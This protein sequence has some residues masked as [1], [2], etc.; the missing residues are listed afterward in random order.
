MHNQAV[1]GVIEALLIVAM[2]AMIIAIIQLQ[3]IPQVMT[4]K[5]AEHMDQVFNQFSSLKS[6]I[7]LQA[8]TQSSAPI[9]SMITLDSKGLPYFIT[10][11]SFGELKVEENSQYKITM[12]PPPGSLPSGTVTLTSIEYNG[13]NSYF[14]DQSYILEGGGIIV[15]QPDGL[16]VMRADPSI[17]A[18]NGSSTITIHF[19]LPYVVAFAGK[20]IASGNGE[21]SKCFIRTNYSSN[22]THIDSIPAGGY[23]R[24]YTNY[25]NA[26]NESL[27]N[28]FGIYAIH[29]YIHINEVS[30][31][32]T[33]YIEITPGS[34]TI[35]LQLNVINMYVQIGQGWV[36]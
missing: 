35:N 28:L 13:D 16:P 1:A 22:R 2:I 7:D 17:L 27:Y 25:L 26:W 3:Y 36:Q 6:M 32:P 34:K 24:I 30:A 12:N 31:Q 19:D 5:E 33:S 29:G 18:V 21:G 4:Q 10:A 8:T 20:N 14:V 15:Q 11:P 9:S 23:L